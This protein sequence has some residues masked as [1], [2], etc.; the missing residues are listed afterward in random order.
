M[1]NLSGD[2]KNKQIERDKLEKDI[3]FFLKK[4]K[5][6]IKFIKE[7]STK[8]IINN[9]KKVKKENKNPTLKEIMHTEWER[10]LKNKK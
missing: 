10:N 4:K 3:K 8:E 6:K 1:S 9:A 5:N 2:I 7:I